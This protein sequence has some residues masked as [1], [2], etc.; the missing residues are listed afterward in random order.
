MNDKANILIVDDEEVVRLSQLRTL[1]EA[2]CRA[3]AAWNGTEALEAMERH[4]YDVVL[5][6]LRM[7]GP[8][9]MSVLKTIKERWP[10]SEVVIITGYPSIETAKEAVKLGA[11][12][13]L[14]KPVSP[15][16]VVKVA[17][18]AMMKK[19]WSLHTDHTGPA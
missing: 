10:E 9:G 19:R 2:D 11:Y 3:E 12:N 5:L 4:P 18:G 8:D 17:N 6:D 16:E 14:A 13:Y 15:D 1:A 7:P